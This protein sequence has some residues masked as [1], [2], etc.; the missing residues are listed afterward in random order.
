LDVNKHVEI[1]GMYVEFGWE[2]L[3]EGVNWNASA[4]VRF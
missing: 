1:M 3:K 2:S 4:E